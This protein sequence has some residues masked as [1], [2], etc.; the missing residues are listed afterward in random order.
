MDRLDDIFEAPGFS[1][2]RKTDFDK[3]NGNSVEKLPM[4]ERY[5]MAASTDSYGDQR[6]WE[7]SGHINYLCGCFMLLKPSEILFQYY[8]DVLMGPDAPPNALY[9][10]QD[11]LSFIYRKDGPMPW[12]RIPIEWSANDGGMVEVLEGRL[13]SL[14]VKSWELA[15]GG[16]IADEKT[17]HV[18]M[19]LV[20]EME[21]YYY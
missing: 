21:N 16:N 4:P 5:L 14:H 15:E 7:Q 1:E 19:A 18:W 9:P 10:D 12:S 8:I 20:Q 17:K 2:E 6:E 11:F 13:K 3:T